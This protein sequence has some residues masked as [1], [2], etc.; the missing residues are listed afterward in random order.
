MRVNKKYHLLCKVPIKTRLAMTILLLVSVA[1]AMPS[2]AQ[3]AD[4]SAYIQ[5]VQLDSFVVR[6]GFDINAFIRRVKNDT[7][8]YK[9]FR[10]MHLVPYTAINDIKAYGND[11]DVIASLF[12]KTTQTISNHCRTTKAQEQQVTGNFFKRNG[13]YNYYTA[14]LYAY[15]FFAE[16]PV[17]GENDVV[18]GALEYKESG[19]MGKSKYQLKQLIFNPGAKVSGVPFMGDRASIF[20][21]REAEKYDFKISQDNYDGQECLVFHITPKKGYESKALYN[22]LTTWFRRSDY[23][24]VARDYSLSYSTFLYDFDVHMKVR[25][26]Q[27]NGKLLPVHI[28][29]DGNWHVFTK[30]REKV[31]FSADI[32]Y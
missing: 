18:A 10:S 5:S 27:I 3:K 16:K 26:K 6:S 11:N 14:G 8:F 17:C 4:T 23:S 2:A 20:D 24:I 7:T 28:D 25:T 19:Q 9:A 1:N 31:K 13:E 15:L 30:K 21:E 29:Y 12:S 32:V 22:E